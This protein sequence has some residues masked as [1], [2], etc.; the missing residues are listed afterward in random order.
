[1]IFYDTGHEL[2]RRMAGFVGLPVRSIKGFDYVETPVVY[3]VLR[4]AGDIIKNC[5]A[6]DRDF[7][8]I[9]NGYLGKRGI[10]YRISLNNLY[11]KYNPSLKLKAKY[12]FNIED[13]PRGD[14]VLIIPPTDAMAWM[15]NTTVDDWLKDI[16]F[17]IKKH[18][19]RE[20]I[21]RQKGT[22]VPLEKDLNK[23]NSVVA[24]YSTRVATDAALRGIPVHMTDGHLSC[25]SFKMSDID[26]PK[27]EFDRKDFFNFI[28]NCQFNIDEI[29]N[30][31]WI[32][33]VKELQ[34]T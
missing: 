25:V 19:D 1:M 6:T 13:R 22:L 27:I 7:Y 26:N 20:I 5:W 30:G 17:K 15:A 31:T 11:A 29:K 14:K 24:Q 12:K 23:A 33:K 10:D 32:Q 4:G 2:S 21:I 28:S 16:T 34:S 3:G 18:T 9:D 8:H